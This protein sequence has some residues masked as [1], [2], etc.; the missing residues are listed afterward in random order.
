M[1]GFSTKDYFFLL[2]I[3]TVIMVV[4]LG[5]EAKSP[6]TSRPPMQSLFWKAKATSA[7]KGRFL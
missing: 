3:G 6:V 7:P 2:R 5:T 1:D 4:S